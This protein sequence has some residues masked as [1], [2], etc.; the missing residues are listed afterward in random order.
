MS[1]AEQSSSAERARCRA[2]GV[3]PL[4]RVSGLS[5]NVYLITRY[6]ERGD[7]ILA[8]TKYDV[9]DEFVAAMGEWRRLKHRPRAAS[10]EPVAGDAPR[11]SVEG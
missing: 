9:T 8:T 11:P 7:H 10:P 6:R 1:A 5:G 3:R 2:S 4:L